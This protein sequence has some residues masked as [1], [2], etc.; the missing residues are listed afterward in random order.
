MSEVLKNI[1]DAIFEGDAERTIELADQAL[2]EGVNPQSI[3]DKGGVAGLERLGEAFDNLDVFLSELMLGGEAMKGLIEKMTPLFE[4]EDGGGFK[5]TVVVGCARG[6]LH[7]IGMNLV[8]TQLAVSGY[9]IINM[10][11]DVAVNEYVDKAEEVDADI[12][13]VSS[14]LTTSAYY[15]EELIQRLEIEGKRDRFKIIV[16]GGPITHEWTKKIK[17]DGYARTAP[18]AVELCN[19]LMKTDRNTA[20]EPII[21][22]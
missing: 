8:A 22:E 7:D 5:G 18:L 2:S 13:A 11:T 1:A 12:I 20:K 4:T 14:L 17:A 15:Q 21:I 16:G 6:D 19:Q 10:G 9:K 3:I